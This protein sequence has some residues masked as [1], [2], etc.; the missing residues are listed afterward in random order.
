M[1]WVSYGMACLFDSFVSM[2]Y[3]GR[4]NLNYV[5]LFK[6]LAQGDK[7]SELCELII[8]FKCLL[9]IGFELL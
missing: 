5:W 8:L 3:E 9:L 6:D 7:G 2:T 1:D 4:R